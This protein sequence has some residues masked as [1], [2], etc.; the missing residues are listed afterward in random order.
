M[1]YA[2]NLCRNMSRKSKDRRE[3][4]IHGPKD[5]SARRRIMES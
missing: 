3:E 1:V 4:N 5:I 2:M